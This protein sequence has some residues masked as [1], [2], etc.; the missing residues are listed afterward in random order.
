MIP[1]LL[2]RLV[3]MVPLILG[4]TAIIFII[5]RVSGDPVTLFLPEEASPEQVEQLRRSLGLDKPVLEQYLIY[6][7]DLL[8]GNFGESLRY[9]NQDVLGIV[10]ERLPATLE[11][12]V[13]SILVAVL[14]S[15][16]AGVL[17][18]VY[19]N[20]WPDYLSSALAVLGRAMPNFWVG[21]M[22]ILVFAVGLNWLPVSGRGDIRNLILP[23]L[24]LGSSLAAILMR[25]MRTSMLEVLNLDYVRT[26]RA[27]GVSSWS[28][29]LKHALRNALIPYVTVL[30]LEI[31]GLMAGAVVTEQV[32]GWPGIGL[33][34]IQAISSRDMA[35]VQAVVILS[36]VIVMVA[37]LVVDLA[38]ALID[39]RIQYS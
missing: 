18:A 35:I 8:Q 13:A 2:R 28:L 20:R 22:L 31:A 30:G 23:A 34:A 32:F 29:L 33:L 9:R 39:S 21:I 25:L 12:T 38:Y 15:L 24:T 36:A 10:L 16:P 17:A 3:R 26:A 37:N 14:I 27:K 11:L 5:L 4:V 1:Y 19:H 7:R 6:L